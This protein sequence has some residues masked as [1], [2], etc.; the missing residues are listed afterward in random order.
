MKKRL[1]CAL[2]IAVLVISLFAVSAS[3]VESSADN[4]RYIYT[5]LTNEMGLNTAAACGIMANIYYETNFTADISVRGFYG[6]FMY[7]SGLTNE[8]ITWCANNSK[9]HTTVEGQMAFFDWKMEN[10][11]QDLLGD[12]RSLSNTAESA[13]SAG[14]M[15]CRQFERPSNINYEANKRGSYASSTLFPRYASETGNDTPD[16]AP[17]VS[18]NYTAYVNASAL[19]V[20]TGPHTSYHVAKSLARGTAVQIVAEVDGWCE[21][22]TGGWVSKT[23]LSTDAVSSAPVVTP[24]EPDSTGTAEPPAEAPSAPEV[25]EESVSG[26]TYYVMASALNIRSNAGIYYPVVNSV[27]RNTRVIVVNET[28]GADGSLWCELSIG[29]WV[30]KA[31][32][33]TE[34][35]SSDTAAGTSYTVT[36]SA[37]NVR[38]APGTNNSVV[39][40]LWRGSNVIIVSSA[41]DTAGQTWGQLSYGGWVSMEYLD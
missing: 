29:G 27:K 39:N 40:L 25:P 35:A 4:E 7:W 34:K 15:F 32:L 18:V 12:L 30:S 9:D 22:S 3:A 6:L 21:L 23:Y 31:Y 10:A 38:S 1:I 36:A 33:S 16:A 24:T 28:T 26:T 2:L 14:D 8:L 19:N 37:L 11:Y 20:R 5:Y 41:Y 13:Y 17:E